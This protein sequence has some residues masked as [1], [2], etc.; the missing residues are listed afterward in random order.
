MATGF[1]EPPALCR[2]A[3]ADPSAELPAVALGFVRLADEVVPAVAIRAQDPL[4]AEQND[5]ARGMEVG[6]G[7]E[8]LAEV[9]L[10]PTHVAHDEDVE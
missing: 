8:G 6:D 9:A 4:I 3:L 5:D 10:E 2:K 1:T 7:V